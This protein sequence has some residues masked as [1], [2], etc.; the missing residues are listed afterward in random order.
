M[1]N[2]GTIAERHIYPGGN[3]AGWKERYVITDLGKS[4]V[5]NIEIDEAHRKII[6]AIS[7]EWKYKS[8]EDILAHVGQIWFEENK[9]PPANSNPV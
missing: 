2:T 7:R 8:E 9:I 3:R 5:E 1:L 4:A 6:D